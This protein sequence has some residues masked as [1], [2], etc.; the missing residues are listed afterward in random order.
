[1]VYTTSLDGKVVRTIEVYIKSQNQNSIVFL[2][3]QERGKGP[4]A[5]GRDGNI[6]STRLMAYHNNKSLRIMSS[7]PNSTTYS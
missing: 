3:Q 2:A 4:S 7:Q 1:M 5:L 6:N